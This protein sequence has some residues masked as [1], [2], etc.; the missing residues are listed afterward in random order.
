MRCKQPL[1]DLNPINAQLNPISHLLASLGAHPIVHVSR[2]WVNEMSG[3]CKVK[4]EALD[5]TIWRTR[6][7][8]SY[9]PVVREIKVKVKLRI[10]ALQHHS[11]KAYCALTPKEFLHTERYTAPQLAKEKSM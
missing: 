5:R 4:E 2:I 3:Y 7:E 6:I 9:G 8:R 1:D 11:L 10:G